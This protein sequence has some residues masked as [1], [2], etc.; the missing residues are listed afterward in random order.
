MSEFQLSLLSIGGIV[1]VLVY[2]YGH[3][4]QWRYRRRLN[5]DYE[6]QA[7]T[8]KAMVKP[9]PNSPQVPPQ[10]IVKEASPVNHF[11]AEPVEIFS[12]LDEKSDFIVTVLPKFPINAN[13][14]DGFWQRRFDYGKTVHTFGCNAN[15]GAWERLIPESNVS[16]SEIKIGLQLVDRNGAI[17]D[18]RLSD[19]R[20]LLSDIGRKLDADMM[21]PLIEEALYKAIDLDKFCADVDQIIGINILPNEARTLFA[22]EVASAAQ[23]VG[24]T[25]QADGTFHQFDETGATLFT[26][27]ISD[28]TPFQHHTLEQVR[29][30]SLTLLLDIPRVN[31]P[32]Q[33][34]DE[35]TKLATTLAINLRGSLVDDQR[36]TLTQTAL[37][38]IRAQVES[39]EQRMQKGGVLPGSP[40]ALRLFS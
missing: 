15:T 34:F 28:G 18:T 14:L 19:F 20:S 35:M 3:W 23:T 6:T 37:V 40:Q 4:Q 2:V 11:I 26:L 36:V 7:A 12:Q 5:K 13:A 8:V 25:L 27:G 10:D 29:V 24:M 22:S 31:K 39:V 38:Q 33:R 1:V 32:T 17:T 9:A 21:L 16:Y 30:D